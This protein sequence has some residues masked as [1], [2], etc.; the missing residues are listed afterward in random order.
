MNCLTFTSDTGLHVSYACALIENIQH[1]KAKKFYGPEGLKANGVRP[2]DSL[3]MVKFTDGG[4]T[5]FSDHWFLS[6]C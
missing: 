3:L 1:G 6:F 2:N 4:V 5:S